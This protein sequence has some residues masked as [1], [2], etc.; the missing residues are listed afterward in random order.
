M[1]PLSPRTDPEGFWL[2]GLLF[3][4]GAMAGQLPMKKL[5]P[6]E[7]EKLANVALPAA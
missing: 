6:S 4:V 1:S 3:K 5:R 2:S 7:G